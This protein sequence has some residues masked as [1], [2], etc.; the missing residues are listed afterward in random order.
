M[1]GR[2]INIPDA[3]SRTARRPSFRIAEIRREPQR[4]IDIFRASAVVI[5]DKPRFR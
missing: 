4:S 1:V 2:N 5:P 3:H